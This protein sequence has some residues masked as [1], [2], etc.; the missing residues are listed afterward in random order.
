M[1]SNNN[2]TRSNDNSI[3]IDDDKV[4]VDTTLREAPPG[5][6]SGEYNLGSSFT[7]TKR[8][9][10]RSYSEEKVMKE[11]FLKGMNYQYF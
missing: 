6:R 11:P 1:E 2:Q 10:K 3:I 9:R 5:S 7:P 4:E 8:N